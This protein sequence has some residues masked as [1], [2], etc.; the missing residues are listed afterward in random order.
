MPRP[1]RYV[2]RLVRI[3]LLPAV[4]AATAAVPAAA[5]PHTDVRTYENDPV[6]QPPTG[7]TTPSGA[8]PA[9]VTDTRGFH[10]RNS[11]RISDPATDASTETDC[12]QPAQH[13]AR[14][15]F[16]AYP[17]ALP[18]GFLV[19]LLGEQQGISGTSAVFHLSVDADGGIR[20]YDGAGWTRVAPAGTV[21]TGRWNAIEVR[22]PT[23][24]SAARVYVA[25]RYV[26]EGGPVGVRALADLTGY[27]F[28]SDG[29]A[30]AGDDVYL[31][32]VGYGP[33]SDTPPPGGTAP[34]TVAPPVAVDQSATPLQMPNAAVTVP[35][36]GGG[37][38]ILLAYPAHSDDAQTNGTRFAYSDD[39]GTT[40]V[41]DQAANPMP[42]AASYNLTRLRNGDLLAVSY[43]TYMVPGSGD[44]KAE[45]DSSVSHDNGATWTAR[46]GDMTTPTAMRTI[47]STTDRPGS[48]LG[49]Y[50]LVHPAVEDPDG[51]L[52][53]SAYGYYA[54][55]TKY[56]QLVLRST[57][58]GLHWTVASTVAV[59]P[60]L[61]SDPRYEG[62]CEGALERVADGSL[63]I[64]M[65][66]GSYQ[67]MYTARSTD[68]GATWT[69]AEKLLAGPDRQ[70]VVSVYPSLTLL[71]GGP[72]V[73]M[74]GRPGL[75][76]LSSPDGS[77]HSWTR[78]V[79]ADYRN[80][81]NGVLLPLGGRRMM[82][83]GDRGANW[84][85]PTPDP[86]QVWSRRIEVSR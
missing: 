57:D 31:D 23:D 62:F 82:L 80:S 68:N 30:P 75:A 48:P 52:Y 53:Q 22:V 33:A 29:T 5:A 38:R 27:R 21:R 14:L 63:L 61:S 37:R 20:W 85:K 84:S 58:G 12:A 16:E 15:S 19:D 47:S 78:P 34:F 73:L 13:G 17:A 32:D 42:D 54:G 7:C 55:D 9:L 64:V 11:L 79:E 2:S 39:G 25:G 86:Y 70:Q 35:R 10:S 66:T 76:L 24:Q 4:L 72:L 26:G 51:T 71:P 59:D 81:A 1:Q 44:L 36:P 69:P 56:R 67:P 46:T 45:V 60:G 49:G 28:S 43:H 77:G 40:W 74:V 8:A 65:R 18:N 3:L 50:V 6:G 41:P 83:F